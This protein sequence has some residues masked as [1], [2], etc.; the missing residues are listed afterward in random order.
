MRKLITLSTLVLCIVGC[1]SSD[2][3]S[4]DLSTT[5]TPD[6]SMTAPKPD[7]TVVSVCG[8][9]GDPGNSVGVGKYCMQASD[10]SG[11]TKAKIC[12][13]IQSTDTFF[14][15]TTCATS[16]D[17]GEAAGCFATDGTPCPGTGLC[18]CTPLSC[19]PPGDF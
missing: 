6:L 4:N 19:L 1:G 5:P 2:T 18:G 14:C 15:T 7:M 12:T 13:T 9:P 10:C 3:S 8:H 16:A 11:N 17:C